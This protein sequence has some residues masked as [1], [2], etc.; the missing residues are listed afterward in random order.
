M[1][2]NPNTEEAYKLLHNGT[3]ALA[4]AE[5]QGLRVD[6]DYLGKQKKRI[7]RKILHLEKQFL[8]SAFFKGW[9][10]STTKSI[11]IYSNHQLGHYLYKIKKIVPE[12]TT[13]SGEG[14]TNEET[15]TQLGIPELKILMRIRKLKKIRDTYFEQF[16]R[17]QV[18]GVLHPSFNLHLVKTHRSSSSN[19]NFQNIPKRDKEAMLLTRNAL[20]PRKGYQLLEADYSG[21][22]VR[23]AAC[24]H[25]DST[26]LKYIKDPTTDMHRDMAMQIF[27]LK[28]FDKHN[29]EHKTLRAAAKNGF[30][31]PQFY[32]DYYGNNAISIASDWCGL[33]KTNKW[34][35][36][37]GIEFEDGYISDH[38]ISH[39]FDSLKKFTEHLKKIERDFWY[40]RFP[41]YRE[42]KERW[43][44][45]YLKYG[46]IDMKTGFRCSGIMSRNDVTN[47]PIQGAAFHCL[48]WSF[49]KLD[50]Y[51]RQENWKTRLIGQIHDSIVFDVH[52]DEL[53]MVSKNI[54]QV[55]TKELRKHW[56]WITVPLD[57]DA[58]L[59]D[60][61]AP[62]STKRDYKL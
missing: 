12:N 14:S 33:S 19:P 13:A 59:C 28:T 10:K 41:E 42:W 60:V 9:Q 25:Q 56:N 49:I 35:T 26:M 21:L 45:T 58:E 39:G 53:E 31:F 18:N 8:K 29:P 51:M 22:E 55:T 54:V 11:N 5:Q 48:L 37:Q 36:G 7:T 34:K 16:E 17:E 3:L 20:F 61:D 40:N 52:P 6:M 44:R 4:R 23:I 43:W 2:I 47:Y 50:F 24:Y 30:V 46:Y 1:T 62:W 38:L 57:I 15:L 32:G 27:K